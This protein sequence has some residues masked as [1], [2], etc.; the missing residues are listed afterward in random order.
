MNIELHVGDI[1]YHSNF[2]PEEL[3][4]NLYA[5]SRFLERVIELKEKE[6]EEKLAAVGKQ[7][8]EVKKD[9]GDSPF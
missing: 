7:E 2:P 4:W 9:Y 3:L 6:Q 5:C 8:E 1:A